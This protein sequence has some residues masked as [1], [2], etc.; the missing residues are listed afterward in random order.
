[1]LQRDSRL[2]NVTERCINLSDDFVCLPSEEAQEDTHSRMQMVQ[3]CEARQMAELT[4]FLDAELEYVSAYH[5]I[6]RDLRYDWDRKSVL[7]QRDHHEYCPAEHTFS[8]NSGGPAS[9]ATRPRSQSSPVIPKKAPPP[10]IPSRTRSSSKLTNIF[11]DTY[12]VDRPP[13]PPRRPSSKPVSDEDNGL[14]SEDARQPNR[15]RA[16]S[17]ASNASKR[18]KRPAF[19]P[20][21][22][23]MTKKPAGDKYGLLD[24]N[25]F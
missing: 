17:S 12:S 2:Q 13:V 5:T 7:S 11:E 10:P 25:D 9:I 24:D 18:E 1:L 6:L 16:Y 19:L 20:K 14:S 8:S 15:D 22:G 4:D 23:S 21:F 3:D